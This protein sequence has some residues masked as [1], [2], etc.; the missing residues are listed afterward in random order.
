MT[1]NAKSTYA[2]LIDDVKHELNQDSALAD[3]SDESFMNDILFAEQEICDE[4]DID[5]EYVLRLRTDVSEY[6][7]VD[8]PPIVG[9]SSAMEVTSVSHGLS[10]GDVITI[11]EVQG[12][13]NA[14]GVFY[15][16]AVSDSNHFTVKQVAR[17]G[18]ITVSGT[19]AT[20]ATEKEHGYS[21]G[22]SIQ[23]VNC[24][25]ADGTYGITVTGVKSFTVT[26]ADDVDVSAITTGLAVKA[27]TATGTWTSGGRF[28]LDN[29]IPTHLGKFNYA[30]RTFGA[31]DRRVSFENNGTL[32]QARDWR[33]SD[34]RWADNPDIAVYLR[35]SG[36]QYIKV[37]HTPTRNQDLTIYGYLK[38]NPRMY[39]ADPVS[40]FIHLD[41]AWDPVI[42][43]WMKRCACEYMKDLKTASFYE[44]GFYNKFTRRKRNADTRDRITMVYK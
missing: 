2:Q 36:Q 1:S 38:I 26:V 44:S 16:S 14:S 25:S 40:A 35:R 29:E 6:F 3:K 31:F 33:F 11:R 12:I 10:V 37:Y 5:E 34:I 9:I 43:M 27:V 41:Q 39:Y 4:F 18:G 22:N 42:K 7:Q 32:M 28:W 23:L 20:V 8:R 19:T 17:V 30:L 13:S 24:G 21:T 15:V